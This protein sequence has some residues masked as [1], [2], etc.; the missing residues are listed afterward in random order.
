METLVTWHSECCKLPRFESRRPNDLTGNAVRFAQTPL[1]LAD[2]I[3]SESARKMLGG[4]V[5]CRDS[6]GANVGKTK[7]FRAEG[8]N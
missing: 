3:A 6:C 4:K 2:L 5:I 1:I 7:T 8:R